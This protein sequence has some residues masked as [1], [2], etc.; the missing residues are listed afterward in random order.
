MHPSGGQHR[1]DALGDNREIFW[2]D[3][4]SRGNVAD[5]VL[6][7]AHQSG[8]AGTVADLAPRAAVA[9]RVPGEDRK[10]R[11]IE[12]VGEVRHAAAVLV[13][14]VEQHHG[15]LRCRRSRRPE[16][17]EELGSVGRAKAP[18]FNAPQER[19]S[20]SHRARR[21]GCNIEAARFGE[22]TAHAIGDRQHQQPG[23]Q[24]HQP[25]EPGRQGAAETHPQAERA[26][27][28]GAIALTHRPFVMPRYPDHRAERPGELAE[29]GQYDDAADTQ[30]AER[31]DERERRIKGGVG[32]D[33]AELVQI[34]AEPALLA[35]LAREHPVDGIERHAHQEPQRQQQEQRP[36][37]DEPADEQAD[38]ERSDRCCGGNLVGSHPSG[39]K[40]ANERPQCSLKAR[41]K[42]VNRRHDPRTLNDRSATIIPTK[43]Q[44]REH[45]QPRVVSRFEVR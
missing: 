31:R 13:A 16:P 27:D 45:H 40:P 44:A 11:Q 41:L 2:G 30:G 37:F 25:T 1:A 28:D 6:H 9:A 5:E 34:S 26:E 18:F 39:R 33:I 24:R 22:P 23:D 7:V 21:G 29:C 15:T 3:L 19:V 42:R 4:V 10:I 8:E 35:K 38:R 32:D 14:A 17:V 20:V 36:L 12:L 43:R